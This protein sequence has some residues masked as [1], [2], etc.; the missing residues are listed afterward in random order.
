MT[1]G[2]LAGRR[3]VV[4]RARAQAAALR[5]LFEAEGAAVIEFPTIRLRP[6]ADLRALDDA[7]GR[8]ATY[9][10]VVFTSASGVAAFTERMAAL[11]SG[12]G[13]L[14][15]VRL[16]AIGPGTAAAL[17][18]RGL[19]AAL[20]PD[21]FRAEAL[22]A[23]FARLWSRDR[24]AGSH[25]PGAGAPATGIRVL[26]PRAADARPVLPEG[27]R[28]L[29]AVVDVVPAYCTEL[30]REQTPEAR[31]RLA[32]GCVDAITF[33]SSSTVR[34][35][36]ALLDPETLRRL[37]RSLVACIGPV[38]AATAREHGLDV[39]AVAETY[40]LPGLVAAVRSALT[41]ASRGC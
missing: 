19:R 21:E 6:P 22:V 41:A 37:R 15:T 7:I 25:P 24:P 16:A 33:T 29:G 35:F 23:A 26:V 13:A 1:R 14:G 38:T 28:R 3:I 12:A 34:N 10:W 8:L 2:P 5:A 40:T 36:V 4:T 32:R 27:L 18:A 17:R 39:G 9:R 31:A 11:G 30:E 20:A